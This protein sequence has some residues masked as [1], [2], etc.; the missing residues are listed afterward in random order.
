MG[1]LDNQVM[2]CQLSTGQLHLHPLGI[3]RVFWVELMA[4]GDKTWCPYMDMDK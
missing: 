1:R 2:G 4:M 3:Y